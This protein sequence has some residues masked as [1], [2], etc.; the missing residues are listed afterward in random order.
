MGSIFSS[1]F[2]I[3][4]IN[5]VDETITQLIFQAPTG[6]NLEIQNLALIK[7]NILTYIN[8]FS[9]LEITPEHKF[10]KKF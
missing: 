7:N 2:G 4:S 1:G 5:C 6:N 8:G 9:T 10:K 3:D